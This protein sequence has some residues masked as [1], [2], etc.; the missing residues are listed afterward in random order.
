MIL[1]WMAVITALGAA[2]QFATDCVGIPHADRTA[3]RRART[4]NRTAIR[5]RS[6]PR[7]VQRPLTSTLNSLPSGARTVSTPQWP[8]CYPLVPVEGH[9]VQAATFGRPALPNEATT[10]TLYTDPFA[11]KNAGS[12]LG[13]DL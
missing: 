3:I 5:L 4:A 12:V 13:N 8:V 9:P 1:C 2:T 7:R 11:L 6:R 10:F